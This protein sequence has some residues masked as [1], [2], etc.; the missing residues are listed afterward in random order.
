MDLRHI[1]FRLLQVFQQVVDHRS[2]SAAARQLHLTQPTV[3]A[4][5]RRLEQACNTQLLQQEGR[6]MLPTLAGEQLY[7]ASGDVLQRMLA[8]G[9]QMSAMHKGEAGE[10]KI[11]LVT[12]AQYVLPEL[13]ARFNRR[14]PD[15]KVTLRIGNREAMLQ[16]YFKNSDDIYIFSHPPTDASAQAE[17]FMHNPL[18]VIAPADHWTAAR[19]VEIHQLIAE[20]FLIREPGSATRMVFDTWLAGQG[21][22]LQHTT[23]IESNEA[24]RLSVAAGQGLA[25][26]SNHIVTH[27]NDPVSVIDVKGFPLPGQWYIVSREENRN[28]AIIDKF[29]DLAMPS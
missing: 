15:I 26:L 21:L 10:L 14:Y 3:S 19:P 24:I 11:A 27:G 9:E 5:I 12:T 28:R 8:C 18:V 16:R 4:Q 7:R 22:H 17:A 29:R 13:V 25:V 6:R 1:N 23:Q 20:R 2:I